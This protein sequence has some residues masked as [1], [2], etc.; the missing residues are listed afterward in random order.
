MID[1]EDFSRMEIRVAT[2]VAAEPLDNARVPALVLSLDF[3]DGD[4]R[5]S[6]ARITDRYQ[7]GDLVGTQVMAVTNLPPKQ[8]G[9][10]M[11]RCLVLGFPTKNG[12]VLARPEYLVADGTRLS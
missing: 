3:G 11:S 2:V 1:Y 5:R 6:S 9:S 7:P 8:V 12:V 4:L 10:V